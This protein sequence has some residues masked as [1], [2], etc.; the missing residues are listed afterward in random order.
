MTGIF[1]EAQERAAASIYDT[2]DPVT[3]NLLGYSGRG[4]D[5]ELQPGTGLLVDA[6][7]NRY[8]TIGADDALDLQGKT[9]D[10][11]RFPGETD[12]AYRARLQDPFET[13]IWDGTAKG[14]QD[15]LTAYLTGLG[16]VLPVVT[17][18]EEWR[19]AF[20]DGASWYSR[21]V[22]VIQGGPWISGDAAALG[23]MV[24]G[25]GTL[26]STATADEV[27]TVKRIVRKI[28]DAHSLP[29][30][31]RVLSLA[32]APF[33]D[34]LGIDFVLG[35]SVLAPS[36]DQINWTMIQQLGVNFVL[37]SSKLATYLI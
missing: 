34:A 19:D 2:S 35:S 32:E 13:H 15:M 26:G 3:V 36:E 6:I 7:K 17:V 30:E 10:I 33:G 14:I 25:E 1:Q 16:A 28:K 21:F 37:G 31:I 18:L 23:T 9:R 22:V 8:S 24:L 27:S 29:I 5:D 12:A 11:E 20:S 4:K